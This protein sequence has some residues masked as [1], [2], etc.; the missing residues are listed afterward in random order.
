MLRKNEYY[1]LIKM[2]EIRKKIVNVR[3]EK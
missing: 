1:W 3:V 2:V